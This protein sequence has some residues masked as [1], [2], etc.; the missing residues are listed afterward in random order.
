MGIFDMWREARGNVMRKELADLLARMSKANDPALSAFYN[1]VEQT[2]EPLREAYRPASASERKTLLK[3]CRKSAE[4]MWGSG[5]WP[6]ALGLGVSA[7]NIEAEFVPGKDAAY[8]K[9]ETDKIIRQAV[10]YFE[11]RHSQ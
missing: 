9:S 6:S 8:V 1:N 11:K 4:E 7:L 10:Q 5:N 3:Q 2:I